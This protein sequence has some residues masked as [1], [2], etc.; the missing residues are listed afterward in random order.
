MVD[1]ARARADDAGAT[2]PATSVPRFVVDGA[3]QRAGDQLRL[4]DQPGAPRR[5]A[6][7]G[8]KRSKG[9]PAT[10]SPMQARLASALGERAA[11]AD[12]GRRRDPPRD[13]ADVERQRARRLLARPGPARA[14][15]H[16][17][18]PAS[19]P[20]SRSRKRCV[21][22]PRFVDAHAALGETYWEL[23]NTDARPALGR[24]GACRPVP[25]AVQLAPDVAAGAPGARHH[26][27]P[28]AAATPR[29]CR[30]CSACSPCGPTT[31]R[32]AAIWARPWPPSAGSTRRSR[33]GAR[34][35][36][37]GP[38]TGRRCSDM[39]RA[40]FQARALRRGRSGLPAAHRAA[41]RQRHRPSR[42]SAPCIRCRAHCDRGA[43]LLPSAPS[44]SARRRRPVEHRRALPP[45]RRFRRGRRRLPP[46]H[47]AAAQLAPATHRNL[48]DSLLRLGRRD[49]ALSA[50]R[51][52]VE[53]A[54][55]RAA[56]QPVRRRR[57]SPRWPSTRRRP[58]TTPPPGPT[59]RGG[60]GWRRTTP[61][62][63]S[64]RGPGPRPGRPHRRCPGRARPRRAARLVA[65]RRRRGRRVRRAARPARVRA[66]VRAL[67]RGALIP[68]LRSVW[69]IVKPPRA[70][71][72]A[73]CHDRECATLPCSCCL[74]PA[75]AR[76]R[77]CQHHP[78]T[79]DR[80]RDDVIEWTVVN[81]SGIDGQVTFGGTSA[82]RS[83]ASRWSRSAAARATS[84]TRRP[85]R[86]S[87]STAS[88]SN[89]KKLFDPEIE[90]HD[91]SVAALVDHRPA[92][93]LR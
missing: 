56:R 86:A 90:N 17:R 15:R 91:L 63:W 6:W 87:T 4:V 38:T 52:A 39:G 41:A 74:R 37:S 59:S 8:P 70:R 55:G 82:T 21:S 81:A 88:S 31:T 29:P 62:V 65:G 26:A 9:R 16:A 47:R 18:Q 22:M 3:V 78:R 40:L 45:A 34:R 66:P 75:R 92:R 27:A 93:R 67:R 36:P 13:A 20:R 51:R 11:R 42:C 69:C 25:N 76:C 14:A 35:S 1:E 32:R 79:P 24:P 46:G 77:S 83:A 5:H 28:T 80:P 48:G 54:A 84:C 50:Y 89:G 12:V 43:R 33:S 53:L 7:R 64:S 57:T 10:C 73:R 58:A 60:R 23:Y 85:R 49:E 61:A 19:S 72:R 71:S 68:R 44:R 30:N 2:S